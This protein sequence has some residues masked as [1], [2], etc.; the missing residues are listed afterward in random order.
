MRECFKPDTCLPGRAPRVSEA[1]EP[2]MGGWGGSGSCAR[3]LARSSKEEALWS[4]NG[5][6][7]LG[8]YFQS[9]TGGHIGSSCPIVS[10]LSDSSRTGLSRAPSAPSESKEGPPFLDLGQDR[11]L[12]VHLV[13]KRPFRLEGGGVYLAKR[14]FGGEE[15]GAPG[16]PSCPR[17]CRDS[18]PLPS[19]A[20]TAPHTR[21]HWLELVFHS[22][23]T[24]GKFLNRIL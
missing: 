11:L 17:G 12:S 23:V 1:R 8:P 21:Q 20:P 13:A 2:R 19:L 24:W 3:L 4:E 14:S 9:G 5:R 10:L 16:L 22:G 15:R 7:H 18:S 6:C